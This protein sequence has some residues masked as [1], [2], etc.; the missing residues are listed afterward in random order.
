MNEELCNNCR[1]VIGLSEQ[2]HVLDGA[3]LCGVC[4]RWLRNSIVVQPLRSFTSQTTSGVLAPKPKSRRRRADREIAEVLG[5]DG[6]EIDASPRT[7]ALPDFTSNET[8]VEPKYKGVGGWLL[9]FCVILTIVSPLLNMILLIKSTDE[10]KTVCDKFPGL[11]QTFAIAAVLTVGLMVF[12]IYAGMALW[13]QRLG[14]VGI[15]KTYLQVFLGAA[16]LGIFL[17]VI[18]GLPP[19]LCSQLIREGFR[20][21]FGPYLFYCI[22]NSYLN[23]SKRVK[24][25][26][27]DLQKRQVG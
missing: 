27:G 25:T 4:D 24:A 23:K 18:A 20:Q 6:L 3:I 22:W 16:I 1:S 17:P 19:E 2:A 5:L 15:A 8:T 7:Y 9:L 11:Q 26:Y 21:A 10:M 13:T 12:S 14:A